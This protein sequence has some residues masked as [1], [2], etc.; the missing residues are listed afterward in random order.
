MIIYYQVGTIGWVH[1]AKVNPSVFYRHFDVLSADTGGINTNMAFPTYDV[2]STIDKSE[3]H[4][5]VE[6][7]ISIFETQV[8]SQI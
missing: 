6:V 4:A 3:L 2:G 8:S 1:I 7:H 5:E